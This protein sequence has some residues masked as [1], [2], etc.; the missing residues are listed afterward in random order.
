M[1][2]KSYNVYKFM[3]S[4][5]CSRPEEFTRVINTSTFFNIDLT[6]LH[7]LP[8]FETKVTKVVPSYITNKWIFKPSNY[9]STL[10]DV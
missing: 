5:Y 10:T 7:L 8:K 9:F 4:E 6:K 1:N 3:E 2:A